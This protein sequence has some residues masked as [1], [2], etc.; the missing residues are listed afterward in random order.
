[1]AVKFGG[2]TPDQLG[3]IVPEMQGM[4]ADEQAKFLAATPGAA[5]RVGRM[6]ELA[7]KRV[8]GAVGTRG[9]NPG[10][11][12]TN[13]LVGAA[14]TGAASTL[15]GTETSKAGEVTTPVMPVEPIPT[16]TP[17]EQL[18]AAQQAAADATTALQAARDAQAANPSDSSLVE[19][20]SK[21]EVA[22]TQ[23]QEGVSTASQAFKQVAMPTTAELMAGTVNAP[24]SM[25]TQADTATTT[26]EQAAA[27]EM[28]TTV[29]QVGEVDQVE[30]A[31]ADA[32]TPVV[33]PEA[34][35]AV[36]VEAATS[37]EAVS[38]A[39]DKLVA[40][41]GKPSE[42][43]LADAATMS[44]DQLAA[45]GLDAI[46]LDA[47][48]KVVAPDARTLQEGELIEGST[49]DMGRVETAVNYTAATGVP[50][51][52]A[53]VQGQLTGLLE[54]FEGGETPPWAAGAMRAATAALAS[55]G[56]GA[57]SM[58]G[59]AV[60]QAAMES[61]LPIAQADA[62]TRATF[63]R[64]NLSNRQAAASFAAEQRAK[65][66]GVE[67][68]QEFQT[69]VKNAAAISDIANINFDAEQQIALENARLAQSVD[70]A[71]LTHRNAK[72]LSDAAALTQL[73]MANLDN[74]QRA[75]VQQAQA[76][77]QMDMANLDNEQQTSVFK[78]QALT[79]ALLSDTAAE[80]AAV[81]FNATSE[82]QTNQFFSNLTATID[83]SNAERTDAMNRF[84]AGEENVISQFMAEQQNLRDQF[85]ATNSL[86]I[87]QAN[88]QWYQTIA[89]T[90]NAALNQTNRDAAAA[91][92]NMTQL[93]FNA[94]MQEKRDLMS[95]AWQSANSDADR[96]T[97]LAI[98]QIDADTAQSIQDQKSSASKYE[99]YGQLAYELASNL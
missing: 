24:T 93:A 85:N 78:T 20:V 55:R 45:L 3:K 44:P 25:V 88:A 87:E 22:A 23:A 90:D 8:A 63:E 31:K 77:L 58:A 5:A 81:Q 15:N 66:L 92:N 70:L 91:A 29:G 34:T 86:I 41:T 38:A 72:V 7:S 27:G 97:Q 37:E 52:E 43:A 61:A 53:T 47:A 79:D 64:D 19:A 32:A 96:A 10:G 74:R 62:E 56:L 40:A 26:T 69:R 95:Y 46:T 4:Q 65:F 60:I 13:N 39:L 28:D 71:N 57:S 76:F 54:Q 12:A 98:G 36:T 14:V 18:N 84:N 51:T 50:S 80:N 49:V 16:G 17:Q 94:T 68:D 2:F 99:M 89:T 83:M 48:Q 75:Q 82:N 33:T 30:A 9:F 67:F 21:A 42:E 6:T 59:Q 35:P 1:M 11:L 73:D